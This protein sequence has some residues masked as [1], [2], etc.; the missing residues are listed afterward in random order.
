[1]RK[2]TNVVR[3]V[4]ARRIRSFYICRVRLLSNRYNAARISWERLA[5]VIRSNGV[6]VRSIVWERNHREFLLGTFLFDW[7]NEMEQTEEFRGRMMETWV[8]NQLDPLIFVFFA[9]SESQQGSDGFAESDPTRMTLN[10]AKREENRWAIVST[11]KLTNRIRSSKNFWSTGDELADR[12][13]SLFK[14]CHKPRKTFLNEFDV[15]TLVSDKYSVDVWEIDESPVWLLFLSINKSKVFG[16]SGVRCS[17]VGSVCEATSRRIFVFDKSDRRAFSSKLVRLLVDGEKDR[18]IRLSSVSTFIENVRNLFSPVDS[19]QTTVGT[20]SWRPTS[21]RASP[22]DLLFLSDENIVWKILE[23]TNVDFERTRS[24]ST[25]NDYWIKPSAGEDSSLILFLFLFR[26]MHTNEHASLYP[27]IRLSDRN[28]TTNFNRFI[29]FSFSF[30]IVVLRPVEHWIHWQ[31]YSHFLLHFS[32]DVDLMLH[33]LST[34]PDAATQR[35]NDRISR[36]RWP[37]SRS[38]ISSFDA[39]NF[40]SFLAFRS[41]ERKSFSN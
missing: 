30:S 36:D 2:E 32:F 27:N 4:F 35:K 14:P 23:K 9:P 11:R 41:T 1:M 34:A 10:E 12:S 17:T 19:R 21:N 13:W 40:P 7:E 24:V 29:L 5:K 15:A 20:V 39:E 28:R 18:R 25:K 6:R 33:I 37:D 8:S 38:L 22:I 26:S 16:R 3:S 31:I